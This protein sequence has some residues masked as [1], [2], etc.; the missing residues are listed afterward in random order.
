[1]IR[2]GK[3]RLLITKL[4]EK[5]KAR[6]LD[7]H[8][9]EGDN[10]DFQIM[11]DDHRVVIGD[12]GCDGDTYFLRL[13]KVEHCPI[14]DVEIVRFELVPDFEIEEGEEPNDIRALH[15]AARAYARKADEVIET[16]LRGLHAYGGDT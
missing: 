9:C 8:E 1:M 10:E 13:I 12:A 15:N 4:F 11:V 3:I 7:W 6:K 2:D 5:T 14:N 16:I